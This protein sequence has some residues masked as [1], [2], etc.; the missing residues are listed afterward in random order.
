MPQKIARVGLDC[1]CAI[2]ELAIL[3]EYLRA[4]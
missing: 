1:L 3:V 2:W 4:I